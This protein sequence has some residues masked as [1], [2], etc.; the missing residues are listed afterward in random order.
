MGWSIT[1]AD[2]MAHLRAYKWN[3]GDMLELVRIQ[4][5]ESMPKAAG[6]ENDV[7]SATEMLSYERKSYSELG[8]Y[9]GSISHHLSLDSKKKAW[10]QSQIW[11]L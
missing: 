7:I 2:K 5:R 3:G 8:K 9:V 10:F 6:A 1:G 4:R 11:G